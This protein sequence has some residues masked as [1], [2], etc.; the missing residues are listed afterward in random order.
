ML[1]SVLL[2]L[3]LCVLLFVCMHGA[4]RYV[5]VY[6][7]YKYRNHVPKLQSCFVELPSVTVQL[8]MYNERLVA[9]R[10]IEGACEIDYPADRVQIQVLDD[11]TD[12]T[13]DIA[14]RTVERMK[15][16][17]HNVVL[18]HRE[19]R[20]G[21]KAGALQEGLKSATGEYVLIFDA[22]FLP[23]P[24]ILRDVI[25]FFTDP[26]VGMVQVR[27]E[28]IN[29]A[30]SL[31]TR[32]QA[33][34]LDGHFVM[35][36]GARNR[37]GRFMSF[38]GTAGIWRRSCIEAAGGWQHD[39]LT[40]DLDLSYRAQMKGWKFLFLPNIKVPAELPPEM[41]AFKAQQYRWTKGGAQTC[42]KLLPTILKSSFSWKIKLE[43]FWH[44]TGNTVYGSVVLLTLLLFP[45][46]YL[47]LHIF[48]EDMFARYIFDGSLLL[49]ATFS[50][51][52]FYICSQRELNKSRWDSVKYLPAVL[53]LGIGIAINNTRAM[54][55]GFFGKTGEFVRTPMYG[56]LENASTDPG[57]PGRAYS[58]KCDF[59]LQSWIE[60]AIG[61]YLSACVVACVILG[62]LTLGIP[63]LVLFAAGYLYVSLST[64]LGS[65]RERGLTDLAV[66]D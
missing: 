8:P 22:D 29:R 1:S 40:E 28:H 48:R 24:G 27:W 62:H 13:T 23:T 61:L 31:L 21:F 49:L 59:Q 53:G 9:R 44:L 43:A 51:S 52:T 2:T 17:G 26:Q 6:L 35:E 41:A 64:L 58:V 14:R 57:E 37:S 3:Y 47:K 20:E 18:L 66:A 19:N 15:A 30:Y 32:A 38:N 54:L 34:L 16:E 55:H 4:H 25:H 45:A 10:V 50:A 5:L 7:Y 60:L 33:V 11:S 39:T 12:E 46:L 36:H 42:R 63:F 65:S 56:V